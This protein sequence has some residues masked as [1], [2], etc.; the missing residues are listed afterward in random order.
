MGLPAFAASLSILVAGL[1]VF[2]PVAEWLGGPGTLFNPSHNLAF[3][4]VGQGKRR[5]HAVRMV[6][7]AY[8]ILH[9]PA[10]IL[11]PESFFWLTYINLLTAKARRDHAICLNW[12]NQR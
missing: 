5:T 2:G 4:A 6:R 7:I 11:L 3:A 1:I 9:I 8:Q 12:L 10:D